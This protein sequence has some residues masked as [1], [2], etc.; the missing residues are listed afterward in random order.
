MPPRSSRLDRTTRIG[1]PARVAPEATAT[2]AAAAGEICSSPPE[3][4]GRLD[5]CAPRAGMLATEE[6]EMVG[7]WYRGASALS[8]FELAGDLRLWSLAPLPEERAGVGTDIAELERSSLCL[9]F[10]G[11][12]LSAFGAPSQLDEFNG[13]PCLC[14]FAAACFVLTRSLKSALDAVAS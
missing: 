6:E 13:V 7:L 4:P 3:L 12:S 10:R 8:C 1:L 9:V 5:A 11:G 14:D 2:G